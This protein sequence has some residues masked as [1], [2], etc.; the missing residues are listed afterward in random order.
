MYE[1]I[2]DTRELENSVLCTIM[3]YNEQ[4]ATVADILTEDC[5]IYYRNQLIYKAIR[6]LY[7]E[8]YGF[9]MAT[10]YGRLMQTPDNIV[11]AKDFAEIS[12]RNFANTQDLVLNARVLADMAMRRQVQVF[13]IQLSSNCASY[14]NTLMTSIE[15]F[16]Q[17]L[18]S[19]LDRASSADMFHAMRLSMD[20]LFTRIVE[21]RTAPEIHMGFP[22]GFR[23]IDDVG[24][25]EKG[26]LSVIAGRPS[27]GKSALAL[28]WAINGALNGWRSVYFTLEMTTEQ[29]TA[30][31][32]SMQ[33]RISSTDI[34]IKSLNDAQMQKVEESRENMSANGIL[35]NII[36]RSRPSARIETIL[37]DIRNLCRRSK[38]QAVFIDY[39]QQLT[40]D[41]S[42]MYRNHTEET[43]VGNNVKA[44]QSLA[45]ELNI[46]I[47]LLSQLNRNST[48]SSD[49]R[50]RLSETRGS[51]RIEE[52]IDNGFIVYQPSV[53]GNGRGFSGDYADV[54]PEHTAMFIE[55]KR[56]NAHSGTV[57]FLDFESSCTLFSPLSSPPKFSSSSASSKPSSQ[58][59]GSL[60]D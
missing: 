41:P 40:P 30:R 25:L 59:Y 45:L 19:Y 37:N 32:L 55:A 1:N 42:H 60:F 53:D 36:F 52:F 2:N 8:G 15:D 9:N 54:S 24:G 43:E 11:E 22:T 6:S 17:R 5:F 23:F 4:L 20:K 3:T 38:I 47:V 57:S 46:V 27:H 10:I 51:G 58:K 56:R 28:Q 48:L 29:L 50:P 16:Q 34:R 49:G 14:Q 39:L 33:S 21:N 35:D 13:A 44:L 18:S 12:D 31:A 26:S 7:D